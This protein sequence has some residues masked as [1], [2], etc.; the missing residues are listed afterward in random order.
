MCEISVIIPC[1]NSERYIEFCIKK[2]EEQTFKDFEVIVVDDCST[3]NTLALLEKIKLNTTLYLKIVHLE[4]NSGP[5]VAR[6]KGIENANGNYLA[7]CDSD[8]YYEKNFL[9][10]MYKSLKKEKADIVMC[11]S[12]LKMSDGSYRN[13]SYTQVFDIYT[14]KEDYIALSRTSL[15]YLMIKKEILKNI[16]IPALRN[17]EDMAIIPI[18]LQRASNIIHVNKT[19]Y[20][21]CVR[22]NSASTAPTLKSFSDLVECQ[23]I[24]KESWGDENIDAL[25]FIG[26]KN[27]L[28]SATLIGI[29]ANANKKQIYDIVNQFEEENKECYSNKYLNTMDFRYRFFLTMVRYRIFVGLKLYAKLHSLIMK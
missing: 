9:E 2:L 26:I 28:Y 19:L 27:I 21:Y 6:N 16:K 13:N 17:G 7:F 23:K 24:I 20:V 11:N 3:D 1:Y 4:K 5:G 12:K 29:K 14:K 15:C 8:D 18:I 22:K 10:I 25:E